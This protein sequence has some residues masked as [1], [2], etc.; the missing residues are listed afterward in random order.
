MSIQVFLK[1]NDSKTDSKEEIN[2]IVEK[3]PI[4]K[5]GISFQNVIL[6]S[7]HFSFQTN[8]F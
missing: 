5:F 8:C 1:L 7:I 3:I 4:K 2:G 6:H